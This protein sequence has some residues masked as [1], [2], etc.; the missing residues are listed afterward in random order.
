M[1]AAGKRFKSMEPFIMRPPTTFQDD[2]RFDHAGEEM[3]FVVKGA[4]EIEFAGECHVL[5]EGDCAYFD[6][7]LPHRTRSIGPDI[8]EALI[9]VT[10]S[11][12]GTA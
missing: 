10:A 1:L 3:V 2:R 5:S 4:I 12:E 11:S 9:V 6:A 7:H 8:A